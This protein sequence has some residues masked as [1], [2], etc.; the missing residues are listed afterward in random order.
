MIFQEVKTLIGQGKGA[1]M[2]L[3]MM[4]IMMCP[5]LF[6]LLKLSWLPKSTVDTFANLIRGSIK[7]RQETGTRMN[8]F[9]D[10]LNDVAKN[11][12]EEVEDQEDKTEFD[13][14]AKLVTSSGKIMKNED[15]EVSLI[16]TGL[17][18]FFAGSETTSSTLSVVFFFLANEQDLQEKLYQEIKVKLTILF[19]L[20]LSQKLSLNVT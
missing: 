10:Y 11:K 14:D 18:V 12:D 9:I 3:K 7:S 4:L 6:Y 19:I 13:Q 5:K 8:D 16:A 2:M 20:F 1:A 15:L 17:L